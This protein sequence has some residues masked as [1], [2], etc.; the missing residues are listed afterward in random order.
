MLER[1]RASLPGRSHDGFAEPITG[2]SVGSEASAVEVMIMVGPTGNAGNAGPTDRGTVLVTG[3]S[4]G[5]GRATVVALAGAG[6][7][8]FA[9]V[10]NE[11]DADEVRALVPGRIRPIRIDVTDPFLIAEAAAAITAEVGAAGLAGLVNNAGTGTPCPMELLPL[12]EMRQELEVNLVGPLAVTQAFL[13]LLRRAGGRLVNV[14]SEGGRITLPYIAPITVPKHGLV[15]LTNALRMELRPWGIHV[16]LIEPGATATRAPAKMVGNARQLVQRLF[17]DGRRLYG[18][19][20]ATVIEGIAARSDAG[21]PPETIAGVIL[22]ALTVR[23]PATRYPAGGHAKL[24]IRL[25]RLLPDRWLDRMFF[26]MLGLEWRFGGRLPR[27][28]R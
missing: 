21:S 25:S 28:E 15:S 14:G 13:P 5:I 6:F 23:R 1:Y 19:S 2:P 17:D 20:F 8:V 3:T 9:G 24:L 4:S 27:S 18:S 7:T 26:R 22:R 12:D 16:V 11:G 10:R